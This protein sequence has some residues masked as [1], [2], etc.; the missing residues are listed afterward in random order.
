MGLISG[1]M[2]AYKKIILATLAMFFLYVMLFSGTRGAYPLVPLALMLLA[3]LKFNKQVLLF[4]GMGLLFVIFLIFMPSSNQ[5][6]LRFQSAFRPGEDASYKVRKMNQARIKPYVY[7]HPIGGGLGATEYFGKKYAP[8]SYLA[9]FPPDSGY[10]RVTVELGY[11]GLFIFCLM[12]FTILKTGI[13]YY[14]KIRDPQL[15]SIVLAMLLVIFAWNI[16]N[17]PQEAFVQ[18]PSNVLFYLSIALMVIVYRL[19]EQQNLAA[20][21]TT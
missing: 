7:S 14:Y 21:A 2:K 8:D 15:K 19:D 11:I 5:N 20:N 10:V 17:F 16:G 3:V 9:N 18:Y 1:P 12:I 13:N 6:I 4:T